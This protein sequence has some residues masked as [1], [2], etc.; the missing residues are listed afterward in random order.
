MRAVL[1]LSLLIGL[2]LVYLGWGTGFQPGFLLNRRLIRLGAMSVAGS[3]IAIS[4]ILFQGLTQNR[5]LTPAIMGY[6]A[7][8]LLLQSLLILWLGSASLHVLGEIGNMALSIAVMLGWSFGLQMTLFQGGQNNVHRLLL[9]GLVLT[10]IIASVTQFIELRISPGEF[11]IYQSFA[12][13]SFDGIS[14]LRLAVAAVCTVLAGSI[15][16][17]RVA[18][19]DVMALGRDQALSLGL[20]HPREVRVCLML[21]AVLVAAATSL[22]G[23]SAFMGIFI[24][25]IAYALTKSR[26]HRDTLPMGCVIAVG[27]LLLAEIT[28]QHVFGF[29]TTVGILINLICGAYFLFLL[30]RQPRGQA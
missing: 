19:W 10:L 23:P 4:A 26:R 1:F 3:G 17:R 7:V 15:A 13:I 9:V 2:A 25:N 30:L 8:Y 12:V 28:V 14:K 5:I 20:D 16:L 22:I 11:A 6:E 18:I 21:I 24:A 27:M 29:G